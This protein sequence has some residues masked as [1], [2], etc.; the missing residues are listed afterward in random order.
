M[1][2]VDESSERYATEHSSPPA[3]VLSEIAARTAAE[4][5]DAGMMIGALGGTLLE[6][7]VHATSAERVLEIG[8]YVGYSAISMARALPPGGRIVSLEFDPEHAAIARRNIE[9]AGYSDRVEVIEGA[10]IETLKTLE[11]PFQV[12]LIDADKGSYCDYLDAVIPMLADH[13][14]IAADNTLWQGLVA[15]PTD[16][17]ENT[18]ALRA[19]NDKVVA[20]PRVRDVQLTVRDGITLIRKNDAG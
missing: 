16:D 17:S 7:L 6:M 11:G 4:E 3:A 9:A 15:D 20:D 5:P 18:R 8:T 10:A 1:A 12:V 2:I 13:G 19:F 14:I